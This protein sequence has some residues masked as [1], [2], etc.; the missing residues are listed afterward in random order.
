MRRH[1][2]FAS[3]TPPRRLLLVL[4]IGFVAAAAIAGGL[5]LRR[6]A[7]DASANAH[8]VPDIRN[9]HRWGR[10]ATRIGYPNLYRDRVGKL[11]P[12]LNLQLDYPPLRLLIMERWAGWTRREFPENRRWQP[13]YEFNAPLLR[14]NSVFELI[15]ALA[16]FFLVVLWS[17]RATGDRAPPR[18]HQVRGAIAA[19]LVWF[20]PALIWV[21]HCWPQW[22]AW[23]V[24]VYLAAALFA[25]LGWWLTVGLAIGVGALLKGQILVVAAFFVLWP[26]FARNFGGAARV[27]LGLFLGLA[28]GGSPW[29]LGTFES[30]RWA[31]H[32]PA[33]FWVAGVLGATALA[34]TVWKRRNPEVSAAPWLAAAATA[35]LA[36][37]VPLFDADLAWMKVGFLF[38]SGHF[39]VLRMGR[40]TNLSA[41][42]E[43]WVP[44]LQGRATPLL[45]STL[46]LI[47]VVGLVLTA[48]ST[49]RMAREPRPHILAAFAAPWL[50]S[51]A[52][53]PQMHERYLVYGAVITAMAAVALRGF[54][55]LHLALSG[56]AV[57]AMVPARLIPD[58]VRRGGDLHPICAILVLAAAAVTFAAA[59]R[60]PT[61]SPSPPRSRNPARTP[62]EDEP[63]A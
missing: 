9:A 25:S 27:L 56:I 31:F 60:P 49:A 29:F 6:W 39:P 26:L 43:V 28:L 53:L 46:W 5:W 38:G 11:N 33:A 17:R 32:P 48:R 15:S 21:A 30:G 19:L 44:A 57:L 61:L 50:L 63:T 58:L 13:S 35:A 23:G 55:L 18:S 2:L 7:W 47:Y 4:L 12:N 3:L 34:L 41:L 54:V 8:F 24:A 62:G 40:A 36:L 20:N 51:F 14:L 59:A 42:L 52:L 16:V 37:C 22:D 45:R 10:A 1:M